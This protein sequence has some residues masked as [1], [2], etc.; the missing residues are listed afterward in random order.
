VL[1][2]GAG[3]DLLIGGSGSDI[4]E[5][6]FGDD[7]DVMTDFQDGLDIIDLTAMVGL[8]FAD[9]EINDT[10]DGV[11]IIYETDGSNAPIGVLNLD[12][13]AKTDITQADFLF[14]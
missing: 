11:E 12:G 6:D 5:L 7:I 1:N 8:T 2:G 4:I 14:G 3:D 9:L 10:A 13:I